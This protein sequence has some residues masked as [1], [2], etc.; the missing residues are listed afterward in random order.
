MRSKRS[1]AVETKLGPVVGPTELDEERVAKRLLGAA[2]AAAVQSSAASAA[3]DF[4][5]LGTGGAG[6]G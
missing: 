1:S 2:E 4:R 3:A 5:I 6:V